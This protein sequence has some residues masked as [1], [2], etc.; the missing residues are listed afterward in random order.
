MR[1]ADP[2]TPISLTVRVPAGAPTPSCAGISLIDERTGAHSSVTV[3][4]GGDFRRIHSGDVKIYERTGAAGVPGLFTASS[5]PRTTR[6]ALALLG[7]P[8]FDPRVVVVLPNGG[9]P[10]PPARA[11]ANES[12]QIVAVRARTGGDHR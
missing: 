10:Q 5:Q 11:A 6:A 2:L 7:D 3:S 9:A 12:V 4:Q 8:A 1:L